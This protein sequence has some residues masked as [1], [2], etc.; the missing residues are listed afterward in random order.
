MSL[1]PRPGSDFSETTPLR[2]PVFKLGD[3]NQP[4]EL[5]HK[6]QQTLASY[7]GKCDRRL[8]FYLCFGYATDSL[9]K[10][11]LSNAKIA[12]LTADLDLQGYD[13]NTALGAY[14][15][16]SFLFQLPSNLILK[17]ARPRYWL[18]IVMLSWSLVTMC[19]ALVQNAAQLAWCIW[20]WKLI[21]DVIGLVS[22]CWGVLGPSVLQDY[23]DTAMFITDE[24]RKQ[25]LQTLADW[26][27]MLWTVI[28][29]CANATTQVN[30]LFG[31][32]IIAGQGYSPHVVQALL[33]F[34]NFMV[35]SDMR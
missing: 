12:G 17:R 31:P 3:I 27:I 8:L 34:T 1:S 10:M 14:Y 16:G 33:A 20:P 22:L 23:P 4:L 28:D 5:T 2:A 35:F 15:L 11:A 30:G 9:N 21:F 7:L 13:I 18:S 25:V 26:K 6:E 29:F 32:T 24:D 19:T